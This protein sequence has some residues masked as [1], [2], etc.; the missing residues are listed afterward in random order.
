MA[1]APFKTV[2]TRIEKDDQ[3]LVTWV[4]PWY[5]EE[6]GHFFTVGS[7][8][9]DGAKE[10]GRTARDVE[11]AGA[12]VD[13]SWSGY[14]G[15][16][17]EQ[18][19]PTYEWDPV[20][21]EEK[22]TAHPNWAKIKEEYRGRW[23]AEDK[24]AVFPEFLPR[25][26]TGL[27]NGSGFVPGIGTVNTSLRKKNPMFDVE[28]YNL[29]MA[30]FRMTYLLKEIPQSMLE[31]VGDIRPSV[32]GGY[33]TPQGRDWLIMPPKISEKGEGDSKVYRVSEEWL[34]SAPGGWPKKVYGLIQ[35]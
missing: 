35:I 3:N 15:D 14:V 21:K 4:E 2:G 13:I 16:D 20:F 24:R 30:T 5:F 31:S 33:P 22:I 12:I 18:E 1:Q 28:T 19:P 8:P 9:F 25:P 29:F 32:P 27:S 6:P 7:A 34:M 11:G 17:P 10:E 26:V 23:D